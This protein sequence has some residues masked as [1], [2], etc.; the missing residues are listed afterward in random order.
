MLWFSKA[1]LKSSLLWLGLGVTLGVAMAANPLW[2]VYRTAHLH[3]LVLGF[4][5]MMIFGVAYHVI[6]RF[7]GNA[8]RSTRAG[9][10]Q[11]WISNGGLAAMAVGFMLRAQGR[12]SG[13]PVLVVGG[14]LSALGAYGFIWNIWR[15]IDGPRGLRAAA[16]RAN[17]TAE[18]PRRLSVLP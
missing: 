10:V 3:M 16:D 18:S 12:P 15:T 11:W 5:G 1:F 8:L 17:Q 14:V 2:A 6:P 9:G 4:V 7:T 13:T